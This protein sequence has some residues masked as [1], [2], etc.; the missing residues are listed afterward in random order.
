[1][2]LTFDLNIYYSLNCFK[3]TVNNL[4]I[5]SDNAECN[6][7]RARAKS[8]KKSS[9]IKG[10]Y[11]RKRQTLV[12]N[13]EEET[14]A[15]PYMLKL[16][17][18]FSEGTLVCDSKIE[19]PWKEIALKSKEI[20]IRR[21]IAS[22]LKSTSLETEIELQVTDLEE[23]VSNDNVALPWRQLVISGVVQQKN[24]STLGLEQCDSKLEM[25][26]DILVFD[27][28]VKINPTPDEMVS[29]KKE[30]VEIPWND[31]M[32]PQNLVIEAKKI[33]EHPS[34]RHPPRSATTGKHRGCP[35]CIRARKE[36]R[37]QS[38]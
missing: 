38:K 30:D 3:L 14:W 13:P 26:W 20:K 22:K 35:P 11:S 19:L 29:C 34:N 37:K 12:F 16:V 9:S 1:M 36:L 31:L 10:K 32:I 23:K 21:D 18:E 25:P 8:S 17:K 15:E 27:S 5:Y 4:F 7:K 6:C 2:L 33:I 24:N 28:P